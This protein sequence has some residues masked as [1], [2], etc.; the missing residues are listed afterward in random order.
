MRGSDVRA[1][2]PVEHAAGTTPHDLEHLLVGCSPAMHHLRWLVRKIGPSSLP[3]LVH[4]P[5][6]SGKELVARALHTLSRRSGRFVAV[7][8]CAVSE[9]LFESSVFGHVRGAFTGAV[10][11][12]DGV[13]A[14]AHRGTLFLDE[15]G[16]LS[17]GSQAKLLRAIETREFRPVGALH[18]RTSDFRIITATHVDLHRAAA[19]RQFRDDLLFRLC[20]AVISVPPLNDRPEDIPLLACRFAGRERGGMHAATHTDGPAMPLCGC[21]ATD[22]W[23]EIQRQGS[24]TCRWIDARAVDHLVRQDWRGNVRELRSVIECAAV[25]CATPRI[26]RAAVEDALRVRGATAH[27]LRDSRRADHNQVLL[28][29]LREHRW[30][31]SAAADAL[32]VHRATLYRRLKHLPGA[33]GNTRSHAR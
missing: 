9:S 3:V 14:E 13:L 32:G 33:N 28:A 4:G 23:Q 26:S 24:Q 21:V 8:A 16:D 20:G 18:D 17:I 7:N 27:P 2:A 22:G 15:V 25:L 1:T 31:V 5:T 29:A 6:G 19:A 30:D 11:D 10:R 12:H